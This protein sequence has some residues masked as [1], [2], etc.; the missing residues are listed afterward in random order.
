MLNR[1]LREIAG[2]GISPLLPNVDGDAQRL[3][4]VALDVF[5][6]ALT[7]TNRQATALG[8]LS[9]GVGSTQFFSVRQCRVHQI[10]KKITAVAEPLG[11]R[12]LTL[13]DDLL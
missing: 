1:R 8:R 4:A 11:R 2:S 6:L 12:M 7:H 3:V 9:S 13:L 10:F 5:K